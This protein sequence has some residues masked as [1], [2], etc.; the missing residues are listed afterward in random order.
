M[1]AVPICVAI[2]GPLASVTLNRPEKRNAMTLAMWRETRRAFETLGQSRSVRGIVLT[3]A[4]DSFSVGADVGEFAD[5]RGSAGAARDYERSVD[6]CADA[7]AGVGQPTV[8]AISGYCLGGGCHLALACDFRIAA[9][10]A[11]IG[12][13]AAKLSIVYGL[14]STQRLLALV[15]LTAAKQVLYTGRRYGAEDALAMGLI[16]GIDDDPWRAARAM[17]GEMADNAPLSISGAKAILTELSMGHGRLD[18]TRADG[19]IDRAA[20]S[21]DYAEGRQAFAEK[22]T[23]R[24]KGE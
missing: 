5:V 24:F 1:V 7:I 3:G 23:P 2:D 6:A 13:P 15:G 11:S 14:K 16:D 22:R 10:D 17:L 21:Q 12:I 20:D 18:P 9:P 4:G 19:I 8:A